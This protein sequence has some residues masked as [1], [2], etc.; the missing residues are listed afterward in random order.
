MTETGT[1]FELV[2]ANDRILL[3]TIRNWPPNLPNSNPHS[4]PHLLF[5][6]TWLTTHVPSHSD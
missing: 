5:A 6:T 4:F 3:Q 1:K 2:N